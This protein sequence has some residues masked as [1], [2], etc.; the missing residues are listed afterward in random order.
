MVGGEAL[1]SVNGFR[2]PMTSVVS[3]TDYPQDSTG[4]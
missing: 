4:P 2:V 3:V 1:L